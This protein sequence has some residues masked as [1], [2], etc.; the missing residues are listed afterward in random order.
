MDK[1]AKIE[2]IES[3]LSE[4]KHELA[5]ELNTNEDISDKEMTINDGL[6]EEYD[7]HYNLS[8]KE[9]SLLKCIVLKVVIGAAILAMVMVIVTSYG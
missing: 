7:K 4:L 1:L 2:Y 9:E 3:V 6:E 5:E 8:C